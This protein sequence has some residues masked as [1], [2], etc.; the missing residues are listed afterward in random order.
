MWHCVVRWSKHTHTSTSIHVEHASL[1]QPNLQPNPR[2]HVHD[3]ERELHQAG[4]CGAHV[5]PFLV[6]HQWVTCNKSLHWIEEKG[7]SG[8]LN[9]GLVA[10]MPFQNYQTVLDDHRSLLLYC[11]SLGT[12]KSVTSHPNYTALQRHQ[13]LI[14]QYLNGYNQC[15]TFKKFKQQVTSE[16]TITC[17]STKVELFIRVVIILHFTL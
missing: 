12:V 14:L 9:F 13:T 6:P 15:A 16:H 5:L 17:S 7:Q 8:V 2:F 1:F 10:I 3:A 4:H 11:L